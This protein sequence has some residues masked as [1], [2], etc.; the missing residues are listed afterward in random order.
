MIR[1][2]LE[3]PPNREKIVPPYRALYVNARKAI[4]VY[5]W[6]MDSDHHA[7]TKEEVI[8]Y[9][10]NNPDSEFEQRLKIDGLSYLFFG[11]SDGYIFPSLS[12]DKKNKKLY[13]GVE[14]FDYNWDPF[15]CRAVVKNKK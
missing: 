13:H 12:W 7:S 8:E 10:L 4:D 2:P 9:M 14:C 15:S 1:N 5:L 3:A 6:L 11:E